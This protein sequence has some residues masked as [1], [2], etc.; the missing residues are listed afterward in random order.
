MVELAGHAGRPGVLR[1]E[2]DSFTRRSMSNVRRR[3]V[4][5]ALMAW[6][7]TARAQTAAEHI[8]VGDSLMAAFQPAEALPHYEAAIAADSVN[9]DALAKAARTMADLGELEGDAAK[10]RTWFQDSER[11]ARRAVAADSTSAE[12]FFHLARALGRNAQTMGVRDKVKYAIQI[13]EHALTALR[14]QP[15]H[16]G[17]LHVLGVWNAEIMR[18]SGFERFFARRFL[19]G[20]VF[21]KASWKDAVAYLERAVA[22]DP[23]RL[24]HHLDLA[25]IY[26]ETGEKAKARERFEFVVGATKQTDV[27]DARFKERAAAA[28]QRLK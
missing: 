19:G 15:E 9:A 20:G 22:V 3:L 23:E 24:S 21:G 1:R 26:A 7:P 5:L 17:A 18:L 27:Q 11:L 10:K 4:V 28:L 2:L 13:R 16:A 8:A 6:V 14:F 12:A 25:E